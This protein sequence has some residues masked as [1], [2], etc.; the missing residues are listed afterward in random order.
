MFSY[1]D[2]KV[3]NKLYPVQMILCKKN[4]QRLGNRNAPENL[5]H[6]FLAWSQCDNLF[7]RAKDI[8]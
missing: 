7:S 5:F 8:M 3:Q 1:K 2:L 4:A 6:V